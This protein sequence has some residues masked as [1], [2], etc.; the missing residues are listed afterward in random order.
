MSNQPDPSEIFSIILIRSGGL[1]FYS[2]K[3]FFTVKNENYNQLLEQFYELLKEKEILLLA[4]SK[5][6]VGERKAFQQYCKKLFNNIQYD[7]KRILPKKEY[8]TTSQAEVDLVLA[9]KQTIKKYQ[10]NQATFQIQQS[11]FK[12]AFEAELSR[13]R[14]ILKAFSKEEVLRKGLILSSHSFMQRLENYKAKAASSF[15]KKELQTERTLVEYLSRITTKTSPFS[16]FTSLSVLDFERE[17]NQNLVS[18]SSV[19]LNS[20]ILAYFQACLLLHPPFFRQLKLRINPTLSFTETTFSFL[21]NQ[22]NI[23]SISS[24]EKDAVLEL[25]ATEFQERKIAFSTLMSTLLEVIDADEA[26]LEVYLLNLIQEGFLEWDWDFSIM[27]DWLEELI[28]LTLKIKEDT[29]LKSFTTILLALQK[30]I[31]AF[32]IA[33]ASTRKQILLK[34]YMALQQCSKLFPSTLAF[35]IS[36]EN[37]FYED[38]RDDYS[39]EFPKKNI[40]SIMRSFSSFLQATHS[41]QYSVLKMELLAFYKANYKDKKVNLLEFYEQF[42]KNKSNI[43]LPKNNDYV[44][45]LEKWKVA[46][47]ENY[48]LNKKHCLNLSSDVL[49]KIAAEITS[50]KKEKKTS[51][52]FAAF[53]QVYSANNS[54]KATLNASAPGFGKMMGR[55]ISLFPEVELQERILERNKTL[56]PENEIWVE[57]IDASFANANIHPPLLE[58]EID[59]SNGQHR[60]KE[61]NRISLNDLV[62]SFDKEEKALILIDKKTKKRIR[63]FDFGFELRSYRSPMYQMLSCFASPRIVHQPFLKIVNQVFDQ[64]RSNGII[65]RPRI[66]LDGHLILQRKTWFIPKDKLPIPFAKEEKAAYFFRLLKWQKEKGLPQVVYIKMPKEHSSLSQHTNYKQ[67]AFKPQYI[68]FEHPLLIQLFAKIARKAKKYLMIEEALPTPSQYIGG[69]VSELVV[70]VCVS[71][72]LST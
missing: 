12:A 61:S 19:Q 45:I 35:K 47:Q 62:V 32:T 20:H 70:Q 49:Q 23:E 18:K 17:K 50:D 28:A 58:T 3:D 71:K 68:D 21:K 36:I 41:I 46:L 24:I 14:S 10:D 56:Q 37:I 55:F 6:G 4:L 27:D 67:E 5:D 64:K 15:T 59:T 60:L 51:N 31:K 54:L 8:E 43:T 25:I 30:D 53:L 42:Y 7:K 11:I 69:R 34:S 13:M 39:I 57:N 1:L 44:A 2:V 63:V 52:S 16:T 66:E 26:S 9:I 65:V 40:E 22:K 38:V 29:I 72:E 33:N 48:Q